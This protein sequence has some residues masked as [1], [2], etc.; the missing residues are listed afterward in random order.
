MATLKSSLT[1]KVPAP[2]NQ[3]GHSN[4]AD[5]TQPAKI[6]KKQPAT[7]TGKSNILFSLQPK[8]TKGTGTN[9]GKPMK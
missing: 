8:G 5:V 2:K 4:V 9:A 1:T 7:G 6:Q 3:G